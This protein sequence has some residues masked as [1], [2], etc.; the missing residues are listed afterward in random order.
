MNR[1]VFPIII[2]LALVP[3]SKQASDKERTL[4]LAGCRN[5]I[6]VRDNGFVVDHFVGPDLQ[7][8]EVA[9]MIF[10]KGRMLLVIDLAC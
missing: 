4:V 1:Q 9:I 3:P 8:F 10:L 5:Y 2:L 6:G 7:H